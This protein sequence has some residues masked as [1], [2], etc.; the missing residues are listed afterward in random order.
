MP[1]I[2]AHSKETIRAVSKYGTAQK[3][4]TLLISYAGITRIR[5]S[6]SRQKRLLSADHSA[7]ICSYSTR[8]ALYTKMM[9]V[10]NDICVI[11]VICAPRFFT[12]LSFLEF[13]FISLI[14]MIITAI[15]HGTIWPFY[16]F[17]FQSLL[18]QRRRHEKRVK[19]FA[20]RRIRLF[21]NQSR[22]LCRARI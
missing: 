13:S 9:I 10:S 5:F 22:V 2:L 3:N 16:M 20:N 4:P 17:H 18:C 15:P 7:P 6:W 11:A 21:N 14:N 12:L 19:K 8:L 1:A